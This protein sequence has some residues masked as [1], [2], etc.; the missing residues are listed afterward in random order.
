MNKRYARGIMILCCVV[1]SGC[2][3]PL[4]SLRRSSPEIIVSRENYHQRAAVFEK[5]GEL[6]QALFA[7]R[8]V[9]ALD[10]EDPEIPKKIATLKRGIKQQSA[11]HFKNGVCY[12]RNRKFL[13]ARR[14]FLI[15]LRLTPSHMGALRYLKIHLQYTDHDVYKIKRGDSLIKIASKVYNDPSKAY[16]IAYF[17][18]HDMKKPLYIGAELILPELSAE[19]LLSP[20]EAGSLVAAAEEAIKRKNYLEGLVLVDK[21][22]AHQPD[23]AKIKPLGDV[24]HFKLGMALVAEKKYFAAMEHLKKVSSGYKGREQAMATARR[25]IR[26]QALEEK[27]RLAHNRIGKGDYPGVINICEEIL[28]QDASNRKAQELFDEAHYVL[29]KQLLEQGE[30]A[31]AIEM[32]RV[33]GKDYKDTEQLMIQARAHLNALAENLY[34]RG[35]KCFLNEELEQAIDVWKQA[36]ELNPTHPKAK[37]DIENAKRLLDKWRGLGEEGNEP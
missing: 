3:G 14:E 33:L 4:P 12:Y 27:L 34:R 21:I 10:A 28:D 35:V 22:K 2:I 8:V 30:E 9:A 26:R 5:N 36:L 13:E 37:Q 18:D 23:H 11:K 25:H 31:Q 19:Q 24:A 17:N 7:W 16:T 29:G 15:T 32:L 1:M 20:K 6:Q